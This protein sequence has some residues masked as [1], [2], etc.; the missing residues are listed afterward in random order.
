MQ[1]M[2]GE[3]QPTSKF[4]MLDLTLL[5][6]TKGYLPASRL[7]LSSLAAK[8]VCCFEV[9]AFLTENLAALRS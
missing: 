1:Q 9:A 2:A 3:P 4:P 5:G 7:Y 6:S 8:L